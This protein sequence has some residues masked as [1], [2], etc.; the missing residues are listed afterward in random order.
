MKIS[1]S[2]ISLAIIAIAGLAAFIYFTPS[3]STSY[4]VDSRLTRSQVQEM[5]K[6]VALKIGLNIPGNL[7]ENTTFGM[8]DVVL[9]FLQGK[10]GTRE[11]NN[12]VKTDSIPTNQWTV[13]WFDGSQQ[14]R[15]GE[16]FQSVFSQAGKLLSYKI[17]VPDSTGGKSLQERD[18]RAV[19]DSCWVAHRL[20]SVTGI[21]LTDWS[22]KTS[23]PIRLERRQDWTFTFI[24][25]NKTAFGLTEQVSIR[26]DGDQIISYEKSYQVPSEFSLFY[27]SKRT[28]FVF[29]VFSSWVIIFVLFALGL[30]IFLKRYNEGEAGV[31]SSLQVSSTYYIAALISIVLSFPAIS[32][33]VQISTLNL[34]YEAIVME[35]ALLLLWIPLLGILAFSAW[36]IGESSARIQWPEKLFTFDAASHLKFF[37][38]K[39]GGSILQGYAFAGILLGLYALSHP[40]FHLFPVHISTSTPLD[41]YSPAVQA[42]ADSFA[43][44]LFTETFYRF[45]VLSFFGRKRLVTG[46][47]VSAVLFVPS[48][49][50]ELP[51]GEYQ[52][53][54]R[55][56]LAVALSAAMIF[57]FL[58]YDFLTVL[59]TSVLFNLAHSLIPIFGSEA[60]YFE[61]NSAIAIV[62]LI[63]PIAF[64]FIGLWKKQHFELTVD[65]MPKHIR[66]I[67]ERERMTR[68]LEIAKNVQTNLLPRSSP[69]VR[70]F[71]FGGIC[72]PA[73]E[74]GGDY[75][76]FVQMN[77]GRIGATIADVSGKGLPAAIYMT[78]TKGALQAYGEEE[79][80]PRKVLSRINSIV[81]RSVARGIFIS[82]IYAVID[83]NTKKVRFARAGHNPLVYF[84]TENANAKLF[85]PNGL[86]LGLDN[87]DKFDSNLEEMEITLK[88]GDSLIFYTDG[89][90]EA[91]DSSSNEFGEARLV[92]LIES[93]R[94]LPVKEMLTKI[95]G[96]V[97]KFAGAAPQHD[98]M[99]MV[100]IRMKPE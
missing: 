78:L 36:G 4:S 73:L 100:V 46:T 34:L 23:E 42:I 27:N 53:S 94:N 91:M 67:S 90:S 8:D 93:V 44:G 1:K 81:Y 82:M 69:S 18:A 6:D 43:V 37:N 51:Y 79:P 14:T 41:T 22:L 33:G 74:V 61:W 5:S 31:G 76:D 45:G 65:L 47:I 89:F 39:V 96:E 24:P 9:T 29:L 38:E 3:Y 97:R 15:E 50:Y 21:N 11:A 7:L 55:I 35:A 30:V 13:I 88:P 40:L 12:L 80:S 75:Y 10:V 99:T 68:E 17:T 19:L 54:S 57:L 56:L 16:K 26:A 58:R 70:N 98:D 59:A 83:T 77:E 95:E 66:R 28:P 64:S 86:A 25:N 62:I 32:K 72:I 20:N 49:F 63:L 48:M 2:A 92:H 52:I 87:G 84:S 71:E 85:T 60:S